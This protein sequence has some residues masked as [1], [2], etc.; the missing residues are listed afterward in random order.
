MG[1]NP[2][3]KIPAQERMHTGKLLQ[4]SRPKDGS[5]T[6]KAPQGKAPTWGL[7]QM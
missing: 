3:R 5:F 6:E 4:D 1:E 7:A 2:Q